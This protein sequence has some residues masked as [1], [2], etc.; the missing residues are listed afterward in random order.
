M[1][2][3]SY[4]SKRFSINI[5]QFMDYKTNEILAALDQ[6]GFTRL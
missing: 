6:T 1:F 3:L 5:G 4:R 2:E